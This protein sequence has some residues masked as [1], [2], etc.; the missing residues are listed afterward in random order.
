M[1]RVFTLIDWPRS[2]VERQQHVMIG[3]T[4]KSNVSLVIEAMEQRKKSSHNSL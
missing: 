1:F 2:S 4:W 3:S